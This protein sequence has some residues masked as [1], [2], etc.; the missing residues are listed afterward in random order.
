[1]QLERRDV[2][3]N[4]EHKGF[5]KSEGKKHTVLIYHNTEG[6]KTVIKTIV[7]RGTGYTSL[8]GDLV[9]SMARQ[10]RLTTPQFVSFVDCSISRDDYDGLVKESQ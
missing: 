3:I 1:M 6:K 2:L 10:C 5:E 8:G 9:S 7:S 4:L